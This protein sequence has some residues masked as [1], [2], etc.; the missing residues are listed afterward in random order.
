LK[1][2][3]I[4]GGQGDGVVIASAIE[5]LRAFD[6]SVVPYGFLNDA[7]PPGTKIAELPVLDK[8]ENAKEFLDQPD[9]YFISAIL[10]VKESYARSQKIEKLMIPMERYFTLIHPRA[11]VSKSAK[12]GHGTF[13]GPHANIMPNAIIGNHC[14][15]RAGANVGHDCLLGNYCYMGPNS[16]VSGYGKLGNGVYIGPNASVADAVKIGAYS[17]I[18]IGSVVLKDIPD[19]VIAFGNP[20]RVRKK[21]KV[22]LS[23]KT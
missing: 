8:I 23:G 15:F 20:A 12:V 5:D 3:I 17:V 22:S 18:G 21:L 11:T 2:I 4:L 9:I 6:K 19:F 7:E 14:S 13:V 1:R 16:N 10:R